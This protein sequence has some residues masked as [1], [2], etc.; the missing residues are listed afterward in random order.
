MTPSTMH[1]SLYLRAAAVTWSLFLIA[2]IGTGTFTKARPGTFIWVPTNDIAATSIAVSRI[3]FGLN[4]GLGHPEIAKKMQTFFNATD[5]LNYDRST[6]PLT[7]NPEI[8]DRAIK[9]AAAMSHDEVKRG[10]VAENGDYLLF[11]AEDIGYVDLYELAF[12]LFGFNAFATDH[13]YTLILTISFLMFVIARWRSDISIALGTI[14]I[15]AIFLAT[16]SGIISF[17][18]PRVTGNRFLPTLILIPLLHLVLTILDRRPLKAHEFVA[19]MIQVVIAALAIRARTSG[20][21]FILAIVAVAVA[22]ALVR[23]PSLPQ[24]LFRSCRKA[25]RD[26]IVSLQVD[27]QGGVFAPFVIA[28]G[29]LGVLTLVNAVQDARVDRVYFSDAIATHHVRWHSAYLALALHPEWPLYKQFEA[30]PNEFSDQVAWEY[31]VQYA[32]LHGLPKRSRITSGTYPGGFTPLRLHEKVI[33]DAFFDFAFQHPRYMLELFAYYKP[34]LWL[35][36]HSAIIRSIGLISL[37]LFAP[38]IV[39]GRLLFKDDSIGSGELSLAILLVWGV[40]LIPSAFAY[41]AIHTIA[42]HFCISVVATAVVAFLATDRKALASVAGAMRTRV[43]LVLGAAMALVVAAIWVAVSLIYTP[44]AAIKVVEA[45]YGL[46]CKD[47]PIRI[48]GTVVGVT[49]G[50]ANRFSAASCNGKQ[51]PCTLPISVRTLGDPAPGCAKDFRIKWQCGTAE[52]IHETVVEG[53]A[54]SKTVTLSCS[55][56]E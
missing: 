48:P 35:N 3:K 23:R 14:T 36:V 39:F 8:V 13:L 12:R 56:R 2:L 34:K 5:Y 53:E 44:D 25:W 51:R 18:T 28:A 41:A 27:K 54:N 52:Q 10:G 15:G 9:A 38:L 31:Y 37:V 49:P 42:D 1:A 7:Q 22:V 16:N 40:S 26:R 47:S 46:S 45:T 55:K 21:W 50:N 11:F 30:Q 29:A 24:D 4:G 32:D 19:C 17:L 33:R 20:M 43:A 6:I